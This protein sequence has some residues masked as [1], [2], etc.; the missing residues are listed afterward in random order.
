MSVYIKYINTAVARLIGCS[1]VNWMRGLE[2]ETI[3]LE[4]LEVWDGMWYPFR[5]LSEYIEFWG[6]L[7]LWAYSETGMYSF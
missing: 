6:F 4:C 5:I 3:L 1:R 7:V 2:G